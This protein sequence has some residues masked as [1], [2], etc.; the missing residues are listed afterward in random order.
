MTVEEG[1][2]FSIET[3]TTQSRLKQMAIAGD[4]QRRSRFGIKAKLF[5][6]FFSLAGLTAVASAVAWSVFRD[7]DRAVTRVTVE[8]VPGIIIALSSAEKSAEIAAAAPALM[9][10]GSQE[11]RVLEQAKLEVGERAL[12]ALIDDLN[13][14]NVPQERT[15]ALSNIER[16]IT[17][18]LKELNVAVEKRL[19]LEAQR[20]AAVR[21]LSTAHS[22]F[23]RALEPL[24]DDSAFDLVTRG[25]D[26]TA[27]ST[28][29]ITDLVEGKVSRIDQLFTINAEGNLAAG[30]LAEAA[31]VSDPV[32][33]QPI[34]ER[35]LAA[36]ATVDSSLRRLPGGPE[37]APLRERV[38]GLLALGA[39]PDNMFD[40]RERT[41]RA[42]SGDRHSLEANQQQLAALKTARESLLLTLTPMI[43]DAA[44]DLVL[45][46]ERVTANNSKELTDLID[47][48]A[49][50]LQLLLMVRAEG[51]L[52]VSL[53]DQA[54][55]TL[56]VSLLEPLSERF[57]AAKEHIEQMLQELPP[58]LD[59][60][61]VQKAASTIID[62]GRGD[63]GVFALR[64]AEL[65]QIAA[66]QSALEGSRA[67]AVR[68]GDEAAGLVTTARAASNAAASRSA[69]A[70]NRGE[71]F[72][73]IITIASVVGA[74]IV[75]LYYVVPWIIRPLENITGAMMDLAAGDTSV[76]IPGRERSD[77][78][79]RMAQALGV[80]R[81]TALL[82]QKSNLKEIR[83][84]RRRLS[85]AIESISEAFSL[86]D[87]EDLLVACNSKYRTLL[88]PDAGDESIIGMTFE[89]LIR[90]AAERGDIVDAHGRIEEW[91]E[92]R[93][94]HHRDPSA[95]LLQQRSDGRWVIVSERKTDAGGTV[96]V[97]SDVSELKEREE[98]LSVKTNTLEQLSRQLSK[99][100][101]PQ[102][103]ESIFTG[104]REVTVASRRKK[105]TIFFSDLEGF[106]ETTEKL[107]SEDLTQLLNHYLTEMS[108][109]A[110]VYGGTID[111][112]VGD[113]ILIFFGDPETQGVKADAAACVKMAIAMRKK[114]R[115]LDSVWRA[116]GI[117]KPPRV[118]T[119]INTGFCTVGNFGSEDRMDY[120][121]IGG[122]VNL[123]SRLEQMAPP[124]EILISYETYAHVKDQICCE[125]RGHVNVKGISDPVAI[126]Q[127]ID[128]HDNL[129][130]SRDLIHED[131]GTL[132]LDID[133]EAMS[134]KERSHAV[135]VLQRAM[136][137]LSRANEAAAPVIP[138]KKDHT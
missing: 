25:E 78:L 12:V 88:Y 24:V 28:R 33:I 132:K 111:K 103:Y 18:K 35:F 72:M 92:E 71:V 85:E 7:I 8:S 117:E 27:E 101:S 133:L 2:T 53:L 56:D 110:L 108:K 1:Q 11:E 83:E 55:G 75:M 41:L 9:A 89:T 95:A 104:R 91:V 60:R 87:S 48:G 90:H 102:V 73:M 112:F 124:S 94:A 17:A 136:D 15:I 76:D 122:G 54:A 131:Y 99:Y 5:L 77:E 81:D 67:L 70:I 107:E 44:F 98:E 23:L 137:R 37:T 80:F 4:T 65:Q 52:A 86:Y 74:V 120:T 128:L 66:A 21:G 49:N 105:L 10:V 58:S 45:T 34:R 43:D 59:D 36:T 123:A 116:S 13:A 121:I 106:T 113:A 31:H 6:A 114:M 32:L 134:T 100:L 125:E 84:T 68:L 47:V 126:Y 62:L 51:N 130:K 16:E 79:G 119:G 93:L 3:N 64:R 69:Q 138:A 63:D 129:G 46:T 50:V 115:E 30:L 39:G 19:R 96:A 82:I 61:Q 38:E 20:Q 40:V 29:A 118:R 14:S 127:V 97:Y 57:V 135:T 42:A 26:V 22:S 109:I